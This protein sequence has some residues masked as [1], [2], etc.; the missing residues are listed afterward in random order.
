MLETWP[1]CRQGVAMIRS[2]ALI[3]LLLANAVVFLVA[4]FFPAFFLPVTLAAMKR[5]FP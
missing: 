5:S 4:P 1:G 3:G 2:R